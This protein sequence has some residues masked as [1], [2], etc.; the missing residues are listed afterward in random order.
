MIA[1]VLNS[2]KLSLPLTLGARRKR[3]HS[4][5]SGRAVNPIGYL[6]TGVL[7]CGDNLER[8]AEFPDE[9]IDLVY[10]DPP[11]FSNRQYE[12]IW[13]DEA[14]VRSFEDRWQGG[15]HHYIQWMRDRLRLLHRVLKPTGCLYLH[16]D[17]TASHYLKV[18]LDDIFGEERF[19]NEIIWQRTISKSLM[20]RRLPSNHDVILTYQKSQD[21]TWNEEAVFTPYVEGELDEKTAGKYRYRDSDGRLYRLD[22]LI[23]PNPDRPNL[24]YE[25]LGVT[26]VWR[27]TNERMQKAYEQGLVIQTKPGRVPQLKRYLDEQRGRPL[28][29][30][31]TDIAPINS[32]ARERLGYP[33]QKP[34]ELLE[35]LLLLSSDKGDI[36]LD[37]FCGCGTTLAVAERLGRQWIGIDISPTAINL[38]R[39]RL[40]KLG[41][42][43]IKAY[44]LPQTED[45]LRALKPFEFQNWIIQQVHGTHAPRK[46]G[47]MGIDGFSFFERL[48]IQVKQSERVGRNVVDNFETAIRRDGKHKGYVFAFSFT[49]GAHEEAAR[50]KSEGLEIALVRVTDLLG[51]PPLPPVSPIEPGRDMMVDLREAIRRAQQEAAG[52]RPERSA[53]ELVE[54]DTAGVERV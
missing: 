43:S 20:S 54:S 10:L 17:P 48:P 29:D 30:V 25:L 37:P 19:R 8:L 36:V 28:G 40:T 34:E 52:S 32:R 44:G 46:S 27:W 26:R 53:A 50:V 23:N 31:W 2:W 24:T 51:P 33:T 45:D 47:D 12:V 6:E 5:E 18:M 41:A 13:G 49:R 14:E 11:F 39:R 1:E 21:A 4:G 3:L 15:I 7:V 35:R 9:C 42:A 38:V 22:S 16:C